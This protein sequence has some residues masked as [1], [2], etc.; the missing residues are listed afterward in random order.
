MKYLKY[1]FLMV[2][3]LLASSCT[4]KPVDILRI[5]SVQWPGYEPLHIA[6]QLGYYDDQ[7][8]KLIDY[9]ANSDAMRAFKNGTL[10]ACAFS[11]D[12]TLMLISE[13]IELEIVLVMD[14]SDGGD[15]ILVNPGITSVKELA[16]KRVA[17]ESSAV[18]TYVGTRAL[19]LAGLKK[20]DVTVVPILVTEAAE[21]FKE[22]KID[23]A[24]TFDPYRSKLLK[25]G[26]IEIFNSKSIPNEIIDVLIVKKEYKKKNPKVVKNLIEGWF[27]ALAYAEKYPKK[28][29]VYGSKRQQMS[30]DEYLESLTLLKFPNIKEN[31]ALLDAETSALLKSSIKLNTTLQELGYTNQNTMIGPYLNK[32]FIPKI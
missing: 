23:A 10:E 30:V 21:A 8:I 12:E 13:G 17:I 6:K 1:I 20:E 3:V 5:G 31:L 32:E 11:L 22:D 27:K 28:A 2:I 7:P 25:M 16:G 14:I 4:P 29:A 9:V 15:V 19:E 18:G 24:V 26:K